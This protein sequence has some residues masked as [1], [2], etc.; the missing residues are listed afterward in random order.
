MSGKGRKGREGRETGGAEKPIACNTSE[1]IPVN[2]TICVTVYSVPATIVEGFTRRYRR[3]RLHLLNIS[4][5]S[6]A[7]LG[8][9]FHAAHRLGYISPET[10][11]EFER[12][13]DGVGAPLAGLIRS[14]RLMAVI[15]P[16]AVIG[17]ITLIAY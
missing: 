13:L 2:H 3:M 5:G 8:Y 9:C 7:E 10:L 14:T 4:E 6:L 17:A 12:D 16:T 15:E 11:S 1:A